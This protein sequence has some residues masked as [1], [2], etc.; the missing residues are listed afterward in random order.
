ME[1][2]NE[3]AKGK[4]HAHYQERLKE[5]CYTQETFEGELVG[6]GTGEIPRAPTPLILSLQD[7]PGL[8]AQPY[9]QNMKH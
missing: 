8:E 4:V 9:Q 1:Q 7:L 5:V 3:G 6:L 2:K